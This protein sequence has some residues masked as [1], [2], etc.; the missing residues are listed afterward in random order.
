[1]ST[2]FYAYVIRGVLVEEITEDMINARYEGRG[3]ELFHDEGHS[4]Y[5]LGYK[6]ISVCEGE[7][8]DNPTEV[9]FPAW[10]DQEIKDILQKEV[11]IKTYVLGLYL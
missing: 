6:I 4:D 2:T 7:E 8:P 11:E 1:M 10:V 5:Y 3:I 9:T